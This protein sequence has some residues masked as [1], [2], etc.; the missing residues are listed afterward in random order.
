MKAAGIGWRKGFGVSREVS[1]HKGKEVL[2]LV[3][4][5]EGCHPLSLSLFIALVRLCVV[6]AC[7]RAPRKRTKER[8]N[9]HSFAP[10]SFPARATSLLIY[11]HVPWTLVGTDAKTTRAVDVSRGNGRNRE[12][13]Q[14]VRGSIKSTNTCTAAYKVDSSRDL[15]GG[16]ELSFS[17]GVFDL[18]GLR[19]RYVEAQLVDVSLRSFLIY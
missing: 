2:S 5:S 4:H 19:T 18:G 17:L 8:S 6:T 14:H 11:T 9:R 15:R 10:H 7:T 12:A 13:E 16:T 1:V 3:K